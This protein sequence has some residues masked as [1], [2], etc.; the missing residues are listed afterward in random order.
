MQ[1]VTQ[2]TC[3]KLIGL[4][5]QS[6]EAM[7][8]GSGSVA[9]IEDEKFI[10]ILV[11]KNLKERVHSE[12]LGVDGKILEWIVGKSGGKMWAGCI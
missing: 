9:R 4:F 10:Q 5:L 2:Y 6:L 11:G 1:T 8:A 3:F 12:D 7:S